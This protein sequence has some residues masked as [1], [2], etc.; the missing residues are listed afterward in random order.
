MKLEFFHQPDTSR[1]RDAWAMVLAVLNALKAGV[2]ED[3]LREAAR[4][5]VEELE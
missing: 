4:V 1:A 3:E 5:A 2:S